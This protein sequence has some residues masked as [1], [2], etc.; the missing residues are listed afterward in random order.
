[1][2]IDDGAAIS[3]DI[4]SGLYQY[5]LQLT[6]TTYVGALGFVSYHITIAI[7]ISI[8][9]SITISIPITFDAALAQT[10]TKCRQLSI[11]SVQISAKPMEA[12]LVSFHYHHH[13]HL[14]FHLHLHHHFHLHHHLHLHHC[15]RNAWCVLYVQA[16]S[17]LCSNRARPYRYPPVLY[18]YLRHHWRCLR[19]IFSR[20]QNHLCHLIRYC[21]HH[22]LHLHHHHHHHHHRRHDLFLCGQVLRRGSFRTQVHQLRV[23][24]LKHT[25]THTHTHTIHFLNTGH[26]HPH[27]HPQSPSPLQR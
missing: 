3:D 16:L 20:G 5:Y 13:L 4:I 23:F 24:F 14:H 18:E 15:A 22:H 17:I 25:H 10:R 9:I 11:S 1:M 19:C 27:P 26:P 12:Y 8:T 2:E 7:S 6:P 21:I